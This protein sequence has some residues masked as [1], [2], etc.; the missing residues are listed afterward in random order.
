MRTTDIQATPWACQSLLGGIDPIITWTGWDGSHWPLSGGLAPIPPF[1]G[2]SLGASLKGLM[3]PG[4]LLTQQGATQDGDTYNANVS[5][6]M[7]LDFKAV[8]MGQPGAGFR[9]VQRQWIGSWSMSQTGTMTWFTPE[10]GHWW[11]PLR[12]L[13]EIGDETTTSPAAVGKVEMQMAAHGD[14]AFWQS[15]DDVSTFTGSSGF[16]T[17][18]NRGDQPG[19]RRFLLYGPMDTITWHDPAGDVSFGPIYPGQVVLITTFPRL[20]SVI[21]LSPGQQPAQNYSWWQNIVAELISF[22]TNNNVPPLLQDFE[23]F[24]GIQPPQGNL[25]SLLKGRFATPIPPKPESQPPQPSSVAVT[26]T[27]GT[28]TTRVVSALTPYRRWPE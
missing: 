16:I 9:R 22:A 2:V 12:L 23:S 3:A 8:L 28:S 4:K 7:E 17:N 21:D 24:F 5:D 18:V 27:G 15:F 25:Y 19:W 14:Q 11:I 20:R 26:I 6:A 1:E 13:K 10:M